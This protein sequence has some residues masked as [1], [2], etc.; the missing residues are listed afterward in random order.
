[1]T[2]E[3]VLEKLT[4]DVELRGLSKHTQAEYYTKVKIFQDHFNKPA[5]ELDEKDIRKF[6][7]YLS[8]EKGLT[9]GSVN[10]YNSGLRFLYGV[11]LNATLNYK[12]I[13]R[14]RRQR[15]FPEILTKSEIQSLFDACDNLRDKCIL[16]T[17]YGAGLRLSEVASLKVTD[18]D[19]EKM[20]LFI[21]N[22]K[23]SKDRYALLSQANLEILRVYWKAYRPKEWLFYSRV[24]TGTHITSK[25][26]QNIFHKYIEKANISKKVTV[27]SLRHSFATHLLESGISIFH[28]KQLLGH[29]DISSTCFYLH[30]L[31][32]QSLNV[33]SPLDF[34]TE[35]EKTNG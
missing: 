4:F 5:T 21:R 6:L 25:A 12:Q 27:H 28:I 14:H 19:S 34:L 32:I 30:L 1:M 29:S 10:S 3:Q 26:V 15:K 7:H 9:S 31:K 11:T 16:M 2:K 24:N 35:T 18:I 8:T 17:L 22:A 13:P 33:Q 23:G 20:Q